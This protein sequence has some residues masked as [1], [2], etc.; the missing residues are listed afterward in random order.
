MTLCYSLFA[1]I[2]PL[3]NQL[4]LSTELSLKLRIEQNTIIFKRNNKEFVFFSV[5]FI[6]HAKIMQN[7]ID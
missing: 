2:Q 1:P 7:E 4:F 6:K 3:A 5:P